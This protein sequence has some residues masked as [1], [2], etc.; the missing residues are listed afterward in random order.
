MA[1]TR[2]RRTLSNVHFSRVEKKQEKVAGDRG[3]SKEMYI[4]SLLTLEFI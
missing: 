1:R 4:V 3:I 2:N